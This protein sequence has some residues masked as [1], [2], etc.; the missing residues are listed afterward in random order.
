MPPAASQL[1]CR[2]EEKV[3]FCPPFERFLSPDN[4][5]CNPMRLVVYAV[6]SDR[7]N[8]TVG[9]RVPPVYHLCCL[10]PFYQGKLGKLKKQLTKPI[11]QLILSLSRYL[12]FLSAE[13]HVLLVKSTFW[14]WLEHDAET[15]VHPPGLANQ[16]LICYNDILFI[17]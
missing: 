7:M 16:F 1:G 6:L 9:L 2:A 15:R 14:F 13:V 5:F 11:V 4:S 10:V 8:C 12:R 3:T 17:Y